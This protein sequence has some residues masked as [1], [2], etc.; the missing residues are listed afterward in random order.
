MGT[1]SHMQART[2][3][4][5]RTA[6]AIWLHGAFALDA[7]LAGG[8]SKSN[9]EADDLRPT[10]EDPAR[11]RPRYMYK[12]YPTAIQRRHPGNREQEL[13]LSDAWTQ[14]HRE[15]ERKLSEG[16]IRTS[17]ES[18][19]E[20]PRRLIGED[21]DEDEIDA[22]QEFPG[23][24][25]CCV[26]K[27]SL[28][29]N[30]AGDAIVQLCSAGHVVDGECYDAGNA[31]EPWE[32]CPMCRRPTHKTTLKYK[33]YTFPDGLHF[34]D[35]DSGPFA[36]LSEEGYTA[37]GLISD[38]N[39]KYPSK[40]AVVVFTFIDL[41][42]VTR[43]MVILWCPPFEKDGRQRTGWMNHD[44]FT[45]VIIRQAWLETDTFR[46]GLLKD[47]VEMYGWIQNWLTGDSN[48]HE[49]Q[50]T[51]EF[52]IN[53]KR[54]GPNPPLAELNKAVIKRICEKRDNL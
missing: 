34:P 21:E 5:E 38:L 35:S 12:R 37:S 23:G 11:D 13:K 44:C 14:A 30:D 18:E 26:C 31:T 51:A 16:C 15:L 40:P 36:I 32:T 50:S 47:E 6:K 54:G 24:N 1:Q 9:H 43:S 42:G 22:R 17:Q 25:D 33:V 29:Q 20:R 28:D 8:A 39:D 19:A 7:A 46:A 53:G 45:Q 49:F 3:E 10:S 52:W 48:G 27:C 4:E 41:K 2:D